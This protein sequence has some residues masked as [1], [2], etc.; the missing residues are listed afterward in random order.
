MA[1]DNDLESA[2]ATGASA[3][4]LDQMPLSKP[5]GP[6]RKSRKSQGERRQESMTQIMDT[7]EALFA[8]GGYNGVTFN[9]LAEV[10]GVDASLLRYYFGDKEQLFQAVF[11]RRGPELNQ[12]R[13]KSMAAYRESAGKNLQLEG[14]LDALVRPGFLLMAEDE[15]W[16]N[17]MAIV[18]YVNS[19][20]G[21]MHA[22]F[23]ETF[24]YVSRE[25]IADLRRIY[26]NVSEAEIYWSYLFMTGA[27]TFSISGTKR[28]DTLSNGLV[29]TS[30]TMG[31]FER[32]P[33]ALA[34]AIRALCER[35]EA[36]RPP[37]ARKARRT[38][39]Q[40]H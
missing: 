6:S 22:L 28:I 34:G 15:G 12:A 36:A 35:P 32:F 9:R 24:H 16:R 4:I 30:D 10:A 27:L 19:S 26:P 2:Y 13:L 11:R 37:R 23:A 38:K 3:E 18:A 14:I 29:S 31:V 40:T 25:F 7:A 5:E 17:Y 39:V 20:R 8:E 21:P 33:I 1:L